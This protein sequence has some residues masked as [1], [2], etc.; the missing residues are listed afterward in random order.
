M[1]ILVTGGARSGKSAFAEQL[2]SRLAEEGVYIATSQAFDKEMAARIGK[3]RAD[4][5][6]AAFPWTTVEE[7]IELVREL[8][9]LA[10]TFGTEQRESGCIPPV[11]L[12]DCLT[13]WLT[14]VLLLEEQKKEQQSDWIDG[15]WL[16]GQIASL[17]EAVKQYPYPLVLVTNEVGDGIV[18]SYPLG[19]RFRD[20]AGR[21]HQAIAADCDRVFLVTAGIP[22]E[23]KAIAFR[24]DDL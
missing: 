17:V 18:P 10:Q 22:V 11:V 12:V 9:R 23:L 2:A 3:H 20:E 16:N 4:R 7:P 5:A 1:A 15:E 14:N 6:S 21:L 24:W 8:N 13:L 19:R